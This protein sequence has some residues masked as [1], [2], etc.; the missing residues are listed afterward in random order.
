MRSTSW[1]VPLV[2]SMTCLTGKFH[3]AQRTS[4]GKALVN[5]P[6]GGAIAV[7]GSSGLTESPAQAQMNAALYQA[8]FGSN[9]TL[10][11]AVQRAKA[12]VKDMDI[13][14][15]WVLLGDPTLRVR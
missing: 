7:W 15:T 4:L 9:L 13:R 2:V 5:A 6:G 1:G 10:G 11:E 12:A 3:D 8:L 14:R